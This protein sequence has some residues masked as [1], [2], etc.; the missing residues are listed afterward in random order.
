MFDKCA[1]VSG[2]DL[3]GASLR[4]AQEDRQGIDERGLLDLR[5][6]LHSVLR[7]ES[8][9]Q[10]LAR[11]HS[12]RDVVVL[13][14]FRD[15]GWPVSSLCSSGRRSCFGVCV[16]RPS[17]EIDLYMWIAGY[18]YIQG[19]STAYG[20]IWLPLP[21]LMSFHRSS[22]RVNVGSCVVKRLLL[23]I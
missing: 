6:Q 22:L 8:L 11:G 12:S 13:P 14:C 5:F 19:L 21:C 17:F 23:R 9:R 4:S 1:L 10:S 18:Q 7:V 16:S 15:V 2:L 20:E 3:A